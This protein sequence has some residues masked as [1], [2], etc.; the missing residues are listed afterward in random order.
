MDKKRNLYKVTIL[1][2]PDGTILAISDLT[3]CDIVD[4]GYRDAVARAQE[5]ELEVFM[6][7]LLQ[8]G[9][10]RRLQFTTL[11]GNQ[12]R[13]VTSCRWV[14]EAVN[15]RLKNVFPYFANKIEATAKHS[16]SKFLQIA[17]GILNAYHGPLFNNSPQH[18]EIAQRMLDRM[19]LR[20]LLQERIE[21]MGY[22]NQ[23]RS[24]VWTIANMETF[25]DFP[26][27]SL[28]EIRELTLGPYQILMGGRYIKS[29]MNEHGDYQIYVHLEAPHLIRAQIHSRFTKV[30]KHDTWVEYATDR[31]GISNILGHYCSCK[32]GARVVGT[33]SHVTSVSK[34]I[35]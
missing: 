4:R 27:L 21:E 25:A 28:E 10:P 2:L 1:A 3:F 22:N 29:H 13:R 9:G 17:C 12:T 23:T 16:I 11:E 32:S 5:E 24:R 18:Q 34:N 33:C 31:E 15:G 20:N 35:S 6:P 26:R 8:R 7:C 19:H 30:D 14:I